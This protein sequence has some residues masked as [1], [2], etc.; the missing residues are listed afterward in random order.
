[1]KRRSI[2]LPLT[3]PAL[4]AA[5]KAALASVETKFRA[6]ASASGKKLLDLLKA[7]R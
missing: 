1:M 5:L 7:N 3:L 2:R 4:K 6:S